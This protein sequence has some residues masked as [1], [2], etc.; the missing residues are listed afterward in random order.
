M[1]KLKTKIIVF[2]TLVSLLS[3]DNFVTVE[4]PY[5]QLTGSTVFAD[6][7]TANAAMVDIYSK[8]RDG[9][10]LYG[11][12]SGSSA[13][14]GMYA[15]ELDYYGANDAAIFPF[16][17]NNLLATSPL[18]SQLWNSSYHQIYCAN[19]VI[20]GCENS[21]ALTA[22]EKNQF[23]G[24]ALFVRAL[25]HAYLVNLY[26]P[27][28]YIST[29]DYELNRVDS[30]IPVS[31]VYE[32]LINDLEQAVSLLPDAYVTSDRVRP[33]RS[34][35]A[36]FLA[37]TYLYAERWSE[38]S[39][40]ASS[41]INNSLYIWENNI[42]AVFLKNAKSTIWQFSPKLAN[43]NTNEGA[44]FIF[45]NG[46]PTTVGLSAGFYN[47]FDAADLRK[48]HWIATVTNG[49][50]TWYHAHKY[51]Q[52]TTTSSSVEH[53]IVL[54][55][56]EQYLIRAEARARQGELSS[57][58]ND[59]NKVRQRA[60]LPNT[61][62]VTATEILEAVLEERKHEFFT[63]FGHRFFD[64]KRYGVI[65]AVLPLVKPNWNSTD[66]LWP[67]PENEILVNP[68]LTQNPGY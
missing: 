39:N 29:T 2:V 57:A 35:A 62:A 7:N 12:I 56:S 27:I 20:E 31:D 42:D 22:T 47:S 34:A 38:A 54:R 65:N 1:K 16:F 59:L 8:L 64:L 68:N 60:G 10:L 9:G 44:L 52:K 45:Q 37:R 5:F 33:N 32:L 51:K 11:S 13:C 19:A 18:V 24:E 50:N 46:P 66:A 48:S 36:A 6:K 17:T 21:T 15:D 40:T 58:I 30:R 28:P 53:S 67:I 61:T 55:L 63:E 3:C 26:G 23:I 49:T 41:V 25:V 43:A 4:A 14:L